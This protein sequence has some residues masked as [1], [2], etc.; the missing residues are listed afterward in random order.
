MNI[1]TTTGQERGVL[2]RSEMVAVETTAD[3]DAGREMFAGIPEAH[4]LLG[5]LLLDWLDS[6]GEN[7]ES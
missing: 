2:V 3:E 6:R 1:V 5:R 7:V 4:K